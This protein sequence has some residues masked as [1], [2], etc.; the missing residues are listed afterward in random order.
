MFEDFY[1]MN[2]CGQ[3]PDGVDTVCRCRTCLENPALQS[4]SVGGVELDMHVHE[5]VVASS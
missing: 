5:E 2:T 1:D 4:V 3:P